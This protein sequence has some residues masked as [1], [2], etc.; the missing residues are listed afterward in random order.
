METSNFMKSLMSK[1]GATFVYMG[2]DVESMGILQESGA[3]TLASSQTASR[4]IHVRI[5]AFIKGSPAWTKLLN[6]VETHLLLLDQ[7]PGTLAQHADLLYDRTGGSVGPLINLLRK[8]A[9]QAVGGKERT[10]ANNLR[11]SIMD[12]RSM[13]EGSAWDDSTGDDGEEL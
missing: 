4:F 9:L 12:Y 3:A 10:T 1:T 6:A 7:E 11:S 13:M 8:C 5:P 2:I